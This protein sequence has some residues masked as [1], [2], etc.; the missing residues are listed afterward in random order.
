[1]AE[2]KAMERRRMGTL[3]STARTPLSVTALLS[4]DNES[5]LGVAMHEQQDVI[6]HVARQRRE[7]SVSTAELLMSS[8]RRLGQCGRKEASPVS[9]M[10]V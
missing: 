4:T 1:M 10:L 6:V 8:T 9:V 2:Q 3:D 5:S 7:A